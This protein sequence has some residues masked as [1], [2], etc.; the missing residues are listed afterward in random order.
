MAN[1]YNKLYRSMLSLPPELNLKN[2]WMTVNDFFSVDGLRGYKEQLDRK[3][4]ICN[5]VITCR[6]NCGYECKLVDLVDMNPLF[7]YF[8]L[9][10]GHGAQHGHQQAGSEIDINHR[11]HSSTQVL[12]GVRQVLPGGNDVLVFPPPIQ[13]RGVFNKESRARSR[14]TS[15]GNHPKKRGG[16]WKVS[17]VSTDALDSG[18]CNSR[19]DVTPTLVTVSDLT[20]MGIVVPSAASGDYTESTQCP[21]ATLE[22]DL[23]CDLQA[24]Q[25]IDFDSNQQ[26]QQF[27]LQQLQQMV[28]N[29]PQQQDTGSSPQMDDQHGYLSN[30]DQE[31]LY[32]PAAAVDTQNQAALPYFDEAE[33]NSMLTV[34]GSFAKEAAELADSGNLFSDILGPDATLTGSTA[35]SMPSVISNHTMYAANPDVIQRTSTPTPT[36][37]GV[38]LQPNKDADWFKHHLS[39]LPDAQSPLPSC[40]QLLFT[41]QE[42]PPDQNETGGTEQ[43]ESTGQQNQTEIVTENPVSTGQGESSEQQNEVEIESK[44]INPDLGQGEPTEQQHEQE[45]GSEQTNSDPTQDVPEI[46]PKQ[47][48]TPEK[49]EAIESQHQSTI[50][51]HQPATELKPEESNGQQHQIEVNDPIQEIETG[52]MEP[53]NVEQQQTVMQESG[54]N[55]LEQELFLSDNSIS[56]DSDVD[57]SMH[58]NTSNA[59]IQTESEQQQCYTP[60]VAMSDEGDRYTSEW[61]PGVNTHTKSAGSDVCYSS[62]EESDS[63]EEFSVSVTTT[64][65]KVIDKFPS[66]SQSHTY[67]DYDSND[68]NDEDFVVNTDRRKRAHRSSR[69]VSAKESHKGKHMKMDTGWKQEARQNVVGDAEKY[70]VLASNGFLLPYSTTGNREVFLRSSIEKVTEPHR[71]GSPRHLR[72]CDVILEN[73]ESLP[74]TTTGSVCDQE[75]F[76]AIAGFGV[77]GDNMTCGFC[78]STG[79]VHNL[80]K[81]LTSDSTLGIHSGKSTRK[82][83]T[84]SACRLVRD[85]TA[86]IEHNSTTI[87][88]WC[89]SDKGML[90]SSH[91]SLALFNLNGQDYFPVTRNIS[92][93]VQ[94]K[95]ERHR[96]FDLFMNDTASGRAGCSDTGYVSMLVGENVSYCCTTCMQEGKAIAEVHKGER[97][98]VRV[99]TVAS[100]LQPFFN[101]KSKYEPQQHETETRALSCGD[102][103]PEPDVIAITAINSQQ[104]ETT[105]PASIEESLPEYTTDSSSLNDDS[106]YKHTVEFMRR[107]TREKKRPVS[108]HE[109]LAYTRG[110][111]ETLEKARTGGAAST[112]R[113][114]LLHANEWS[115][116]SGLH[117]QLNAVS[118]QISSLLEQK[119][120]IKALLNQCTTAF[121]IANNYI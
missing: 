73:V 37:S 102:S 27:Q 80:K 32:A 11:G 25:H 98:C 49:N 6:E 26:L 68:A 43:I 95:T 39:E 104:N 86:I 23:M 18:V 21:T 65:E 41:L 117:R 10:H 64:S 72:I 55:A 3:F 105:S 40:D 16:E 114:A 87:A 108:D 119:Y 78:R 46:G 30:F 59:N 82:R 60:A 71:L 51:Q 74:E 61:P 33:T 56:D 66:K 63:N 89:K 118:S 57:A 48:H 42:H 34:F 1:K 31:T 103:S 110:L 76:L 83:T 62:D 107:L 115:E 35:H 88:K 97:R 120:E 94:D 93:L 90:P 19:R 9:L 5:G 109:F 22:S 91:G 116:V 14:D 75:L 113:V 52:T 81:K 47:T 67:D 100:L 2:D 58:Q 69:A 85:I 111:R 106:M 50:D 99:E 17:H 53:V 24:N 121:D 38:L 77:D 4:D 12:T 8:H 44:Q 101:D 13:K 28:F 36:D 84:V 20:E 29:Y 92:R 96:T 54:E 15:R 45:I 112:R 70:S 79:K 7:Y